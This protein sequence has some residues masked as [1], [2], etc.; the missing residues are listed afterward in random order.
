MEK[1]YTW[2]PARYIAGR[3]NCYVVY[4]V[5]NPESGRLMCRRIKLNYIA[6]K[7][8]RKQYA[9][10]LI[11]SI[12]SK[13]ASGYNPLCDNTNAARMMLLSD[14]IA[15]FLKHKRREQETHNICKDTYTDYYQHLTA[16]AQ[17]TTDCYM[18]KVKASVIN[19]FLDYLYIERQVSA[20]TR[21]HYL[22]TL[23]TFL[24]YCKNRDYITENPAATITAMRTAAKKRE[25]IPAHVLQTIFNHLKATDKHFLLACYL[26]YGCFI[27]PSE[28][29]KLRLSAVNFAK[30]TIYIAASISKNKKAQ[31]VTI[32]KNIVRYMVDLHIYNAPNDYYLIGHDF[33]PA[34]KPCSDKILRRKWLMVRQELRLPDSYQ[35]YSLKDSGIT[36][37]IAMLNVSEVRDQ[38]RHHSISITDVYT[39]RAKTD[40]NEH[41]KHLDFTP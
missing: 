40:G 38:A 19:A 3:N 11:K 27:R 32:P 33:A 36:Q 15:E 24:T 2:R 25:A 29:C 16:F 7:R 13:L 5:L 41:I 26:L 9:E 35:F 34:E 21:N 10:E 14:A 6:D 39:D 8:T 31:T 1:I 4:S 30:Q 17:H 18:F 28:M 12:N 20:V 37:M 23:K 22:Q